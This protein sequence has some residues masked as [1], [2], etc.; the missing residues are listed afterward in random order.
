MVGCR[1]GRSFSTVFI[2]NFVDQASTK[3]FFL[4]Y[5]HSEFCRR[6]FDFRCQDALIFWESSNFLLLVVDF[7]EGQDAFLFFNIENS[8]LITRK[9]S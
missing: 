2:L 8:N 6:G 7:G 3:K 1:L 4:N 9:K 5:F